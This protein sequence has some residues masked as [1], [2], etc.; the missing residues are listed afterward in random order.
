M[1]SRGGGLN[2]GWG[3]LPALLLTS[4]TLPTL[5]MFG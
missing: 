4:A 2:L 5:Q 3:G 1:A